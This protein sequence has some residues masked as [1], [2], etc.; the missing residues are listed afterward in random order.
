MMRKYLFFLPVLLLLLGVPLVAGP[1][2]VHGPAFDGEE[3][4]CDLPDAQQFKNIGSRKD[5]AG[6]CV[7]TSIE[8]AARWQGM[9]DFRGW[10]D[11]CANNYAGGGYPEKVTKLITAWCKFKNIPEP[12]YLQYEGP[13]PEQVLELIDRTG[14]MACVTYG[15]SPRYNNQTIAHMVCSPKYSGKYGVI[16]DNN[17]VDGPDHLE[18]MSREEMV[19]R[20]VHLS[21]CV[22]NSC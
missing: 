21:I 5:G 1:S 19:H 4:S 2:S 7:F 15:T 8:M 20:P 12:P 3:V 16:L 9:E 10:R 17:F 18:W 13:S 11:W 14:R 22:T 6:M